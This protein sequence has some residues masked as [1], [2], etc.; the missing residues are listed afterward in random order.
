MR[1]EALAKVTRSIN[2]A[3]Y[4]FKMSS[5]NQLTIDTG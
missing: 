2:S 4:H 3:G 5:S 1:S